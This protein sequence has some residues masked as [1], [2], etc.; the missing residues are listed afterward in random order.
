M[1]ESG[2]SAIPAVGADLQVC[3]NTNASPSQKFSRPQT[4]I[5]TRLAATGDMPAP[6]TSVAMTP[7]LPA[8]ET[9]PL[10]STNLTNVDRAE[11]RRSRHVQR[12]CHRKLWTTDSS[13][14]AAVAAR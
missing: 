14:A 2:A 4:A 11:P 6:S 5:E 12:R 7:R 8:S 10:A 3:A 1:D 13:T 9:A